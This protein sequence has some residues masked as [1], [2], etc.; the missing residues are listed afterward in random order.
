LASQQRWFSQ[1]KDHHR[2]CQNKLVAVVFPLEQAT[3]GPPISQG[4]EA[5]VDGIIFSN[6]C[7]NTLLLSL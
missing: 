5:V 1:F 6:K 2:E 3:T 4:K 7:L